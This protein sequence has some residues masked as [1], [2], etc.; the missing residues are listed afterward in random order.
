MASQHRAERH[1][2]ALM[3]LARVAGDRVVPGER[4]DRYLVHLVVTEE[5]RTTLADGTPVDPQEAAAIKCDNPHVVHVHDRDGNPLYQGRKSRSWSTAQRRAAL[6]RDGGHCR[7]PGCWRTHVDLHHQRWWRQGGPTDI[8]NGYLT[9][10]FHHTL[11]HERGFRV[12]GDPN[13]TLTFTRPDGRT[14]G[15]TNPTTRRFGSHG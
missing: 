5:G 4:S 8:D 7:F 2:D 9:C 10:K 13:G 6:V 12:T 14:V 3:D 11:V 1:A 15:A